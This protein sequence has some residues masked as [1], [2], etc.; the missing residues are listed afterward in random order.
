VTKGEFDIEIFGVA[1]L[2]VR[3][4][5]LA[6]IVNLSRKNSLGVWGN[7]AVQSTTAVEKDRLADQELFSS[8]QLPPL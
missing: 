7:S 5:I 1:Y 3:A 8:A 2:Y 4:R 6:R